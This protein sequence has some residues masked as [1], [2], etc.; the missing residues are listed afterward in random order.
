MTQLFVGNCNRSKPAISFTAKQV[1]IY[2][3]KTLLPAGFIPFSKMDEAVK[4]KRVALVI[5]F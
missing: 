4:T 3:C 2:V 5:F 1:W